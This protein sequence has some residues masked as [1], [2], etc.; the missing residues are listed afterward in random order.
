[1]YVC[2]HKT[3]LLPLFSL[4]V[5]SMRSKMCSKSDPRIG[6]PKSH[7]S[8]PLAA[9]EARIQALPFCRLCARLTSPGSPPHK[10]EPYVA[11]RPRFA[12]PCSASALSIIQASEDAIREC[13]PA[14]RLTRTRFLLSVLIFSASLLPGLVCYG[15]VRCDMTRKRTTAFCWWRIDA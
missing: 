9:R 7:G 5:A 11:S 12:S 4:G 14:A 1:M 13:E 2:G 10:V 8:Q 6:T 3:Q 15:R